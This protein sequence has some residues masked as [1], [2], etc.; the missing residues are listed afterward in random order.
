MVYPSERGEPRPGGTL[1]SGNVSARNDDKNRR[2]KPKQPPKDTNYER[3][4]R[5]KR[6]SNSTIHYYRSCWQSDGLRFPKMG[7]GGYFINYF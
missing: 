7:L 3:F 1:G 4:N 6:M 5:N 2:P